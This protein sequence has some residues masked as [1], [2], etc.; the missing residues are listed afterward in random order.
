M[1]L[2]GRAVAAVLAFAGLVL[3]GAALS[4]WPIMLALGA[5]HHEISSKIPALGFWPTLII[6]WGV[7]SV[8]GLLRPTKTAEKK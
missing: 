3:L 2:L 7:G 5:A 6:G 1:E 8:A 4:A